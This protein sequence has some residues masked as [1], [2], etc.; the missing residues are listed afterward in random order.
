MVQPVAPPWAS[1]ISALGL[2]HFPYQE[3]R[4]SDSLCQ[5]YCLTV[6][7]SFPVSEATCTP[8]FCLSVCGTW[9][10]SRPTAVSVPCGDRMRSYYCSSGG[11]HAGQLPHVGCQEGSADCGG[12]MPTVG[13]NL[14]LSLLYVSTVPFCPG[15]DCIVFSL[16]ILILRYSGQCSDFYFCQ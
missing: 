1:P 12:L 11:V 3:I 10:L 15:L 4:S 14:A 9:H 2:E 6:G 5:A 13:A 16:V 8:L 7:M